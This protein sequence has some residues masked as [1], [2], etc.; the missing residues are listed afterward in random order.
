MGEAAGTSGVAAG[1]L[2]YRCTFILG[3]TEA[4]RSRL[5]LAK[6]FFR[7]IR[8]DPYGRMSVGRHTGARS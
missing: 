1:L 5:F 4:L 7:D 6:Y 3:P 8:I 2:M